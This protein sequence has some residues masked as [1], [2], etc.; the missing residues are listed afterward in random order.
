MPENKA[1][2]DKLADDIEAISRVR[3]AVGEDII[4]MSDFNQ[5]YTLGEAQIRMKDLDDQDL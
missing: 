2:W 5:G 3:K 4:L 1:E